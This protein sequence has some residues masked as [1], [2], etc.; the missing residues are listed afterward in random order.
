MGDKQIEQLCNALRNHKKIKAI[1]L[2][3]NRFT[4]TGIR[5]LEKL[6]TDNP[7]IR[8][9]TTGYAG[10]FPWHSGIKKIEEK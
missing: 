8:L 4:D 2:H 10:V 9:I 3:C 7:N 1:E 5:H 6:M